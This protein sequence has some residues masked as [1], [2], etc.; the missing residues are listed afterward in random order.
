[1]D[2]I[3]VA[4]ETVKI[5][6]GFFFIVDLRA[7]RDGVT[8][9]ELLF[10][11]VVHDAVGITATD[12]AADNAR[13]RPE[14]IANRLADDERVFGDLHLEADDASADAVVLHFFHVLEHA[15]V[16]R[17]AVEELGSE[18][19]DEDDERHIKH[20]GEL[21]GGFDEECRCGE[22]CAHG[23]AHEGA[24][25]EKNDGA[26]II[27]GHTD[28]N[29]EV[30]GKRTDERTDGEGG[31]E[32][33]SRDTAGGGEEHHAHAEK[34]HQREEGDGFFAVYDI[35]DDAS[36]AVK[37]FGEDKTDDACQ[38]EDEEKLCVIREK[39]ADFFHEMTEF[40]NGNIKNADGKGDDHGED[41]KIADVR[42]IELFH[43]AEIK[44]DGIDAEKAA[45]EIIHERCREHGGGG[46]QNEHGGEALMNLFQGEKNGCERRARGNGKACCRTACH[47]VAIP[48]A[49]FFRGFAAKVTERGT[50]EN[51]GTFTAE[52]HAAEKAQH[53]AEDG[54]EERADPLEGKNTAQDAF[55][56]GNT[57]ALDLRGAFVENIHDGCGCDQ[58]RKKKDRHDRVFFCHVVNML[59]D[60]FQFFS[61]QFEEEYHSADDCSAEDAKSKAG[62]DVSEIF[63]ILIFFQGCPS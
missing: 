9:I 38:D 55:A 41:E 47:H 61:E 40:R 23:A 30:C 58:S 27:F 63:A 37:T 43:D 31:D 48:C 51:A 44:K 18:V 25:A 35:K 32:D 15:I 20:I 8:D 22:R 33:T 17:L 59:G 57:A 60:F 11:V 16:E 49:F 10:A 6:D 12:D 50:Y 56:S 13:M 52:R 62:H 5:L 53:A 54:A 46:H 4:D 24:H 34:E 28:I 45:K 1:M 26:E 3:V 14:D 29:E 21:R 36:A 42:K 39:F 7:E 19:D 2:V